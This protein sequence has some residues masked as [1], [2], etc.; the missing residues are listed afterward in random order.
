MFY[1]ARCGKMSGILAELIPDN[2]ISCHARLLRYLFP[3][4]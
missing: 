2:S 4:S 3:R 1:N